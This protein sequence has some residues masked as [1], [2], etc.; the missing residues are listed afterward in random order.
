ML[1]EILFLLFSNSGLLCF[2]FSFFHSSRII[3]LKICMFFNGFYSYSFPAPLNC[4]TI[5]PEYGVLIIRMLT[6]ALKSTDSIY[7][8]V[9]RLSLLN[10]VILMIAHSICQIFWKQAHF[11]TS[12]ERCTFSEIL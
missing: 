3:L 2:I 9:L 11:F 1:E 10:F 6:G 5:K 8:L 4:S 7:C 12:S